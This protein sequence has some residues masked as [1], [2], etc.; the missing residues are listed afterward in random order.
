MGNSDIRSLST[1]TDIDYDKI[2]GVDV[3]VDAS[4]WMYKYM[5]TTVEF[6]D[7][8][9]YTTENDTE[10]P[11]L[12]GCFQ[13]LKKFKENNLNAVF[14][15]DGVAHDLKEDELERRREK[16]EEAQ[17]NAENASNMIQQAKYDSR[18]QRL[19]SGKIDRVRKLVQLCGFD[20]VDAPSAAEGQAAYMAQQDSS[21]AMSDDYDTIVFGSPN[22]IRNFTSSTRQLENVN[23]E[24]TLQDNNLTHE[25]LIWAVLLCG[26]D[27]NDGIHGV[28][29]ATAKKL[30]RKY[31]SFEKLLQDNEYTIQNWEEI[32]S[33]YADPDINPNADYNYPTGNAKLDT[34]ETFLTETWELPQDEIEPTLSF[35]RESEQDTTLLDY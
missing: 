21:H 28:G 13:G 10:V 31:D 32:I 12:L 35:L 23:F 30:V 27:Y 6:T 9:V 16:K 15:F 29:P 2:S 17:T 33:I 19:T 7:T 3:A 26:T 20:T 8:H 1:I 14:V 18:T 34:L 25:E 5:T 4:N 11:E 22:T 24:Q